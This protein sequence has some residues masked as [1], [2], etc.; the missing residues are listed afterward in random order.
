MEGSGWAWHGHG[1]S[2]AFMA[3]HDEPWTKGDAGHHEEAPGHGW[4]SRRGG[5]R[6]EQGR[7]EA[8]ARNL[9]DGSVITTRTGANSSFLPGRPCPV[10]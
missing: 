5:S 7:E 6:R 9:H 10:E 8:R 2:D 4:T 3:N 1:P